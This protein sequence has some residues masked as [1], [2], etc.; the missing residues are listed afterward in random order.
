VLPASRVAK[1][2]AALFLVIGRFSLNKKTPNHTFLP[3]V[4]GFEAGSVINFNDVH[5]F[6]LLHFSPNS[7]IVNRHF[8]L[9]EFLPGLTA[10]IVFIALKEAHKLVAKLTHPEAFVK[11]YAKNKIAGHV[12]GRGLR[13]RLAAVYSL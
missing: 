11:I 5:P 4:Q 9:V 2:K 3:L 8:I 1:V 13:N 6:N 12:K 7:R 10:Q